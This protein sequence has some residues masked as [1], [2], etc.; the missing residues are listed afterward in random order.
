[1]ML[2]ENCVMRN[3]TTEDLPNDLEFERSKSEAYAAEKYAIKNER[4]F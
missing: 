4:P 2:W 3:G 1:M